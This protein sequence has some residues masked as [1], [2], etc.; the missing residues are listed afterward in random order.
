MRIDDDDNV[1]D[2]VNFTDGVNAPHDWMAIAIEVTA[3][4]NCIVLDVFAMVH[5]L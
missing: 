2:G 5:R 1:F 4:M 3:I